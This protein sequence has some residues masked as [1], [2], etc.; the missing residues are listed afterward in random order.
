MDTKILEL[1]TE[2]MMKVEE[3]RNKIGSI[4][5]DFFFNEE[6][7][8]LITELCE[9]KNKYIAD[10]KLLGIKRGA[11][12]KVDIPPSTEIPV[13]F[14]GYIEYID[15]TGEYYQDDVRV[16]VSIPDQHGKRVTHKYATICTYIKPHWITVNP[17]DYIFGV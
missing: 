2:Y 4:G 15:F 17:T 12:V 16:S 9:V 8:Q 14:H 10:L 13:V 1:E 11:K 6:K 7:E 5:S 3:Y